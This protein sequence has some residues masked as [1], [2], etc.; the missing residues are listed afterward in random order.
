MV[1]VKS[2]AVN[3][4]H[5]RRTDQVLEVDFPYMQTSV[6]ME[7]KSTEAVAVLVKQMYTFRTQLKVARLGV[8][9]VGWGGN[10]GS[11]LTGALISNKRQISWNTAK[12]PRAP[13]LF[14]SVVMSSTVRVGANSAG[15]DV[16]A[17]MHELLPMVHPDEIVLGG[18]DINRAN[19]AHAMQRAKVFDYDLQ[20]RLI[21]HMESL[22]P[23]PS[24]YYPDFIASNQ[25]QRADNVL[26]GDNK[27][28]HLNIIRQNIREFKRDKNVDQVI[29]LWTATTE[30]FSEVVP[31]I[32]DTAENLLDAINASEEEISPSTLFA[33][34]SIL[35]GAPYINGSP[36]NTFV[37][38]CIQLAERKG[39]FIAGD[40][41]KSG[42]TKFKSVMI[43]FLV[44]AGIKPTAIVSYNH[45]GNNDGHNLSAPSQF[46]SK[47]ISKSNVVDDMVKSNRIL[48]R[49]DEHPDHIVVIKY[50]PT[51]ADSKR[52]MDEY[53]S[54]IFMGGTNTVIT[55]NTCEDSLLAAPLILD[56]VI[57]CELFCRITYKTSSTDGFMPFH[58]VLSFLGYML[59][60][61]LVP[62]GTPVVNALFKQRACIE[63]VL[64]VCSGLPVEDDLR[65]EHHV[66]SV[67]MRNRSESNC[68]IVKNVCR[69]D[70]EEF[71]A[72]GSLANGNGSVTSSRSRTRPG[73]SKPKV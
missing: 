24:V 55:H 41:F 1:F 21:P 18:W 38:G 44:N 3:G 68:N 30:R 40:D 27:T 67:D 56:L 63:N 12:G 39:V 22:A 19:L 59:K 57:L 70:H 14:G 61:P 65:L 45:L 35:E 10:N 29:V 53:T 7:P 9:L 72:N 71:Y 58:H 62:S 42:Q 28:E 49:D 43:D 60:A 36:Q 69:R 6:E 20:R 73:D 37:P 2:F 47:E 23:L 52:A 13:N 54:E 17:P 33:V 32:N 16:F 34:A 50:V 8:M 15:E 64:R 25:E 48:F 46:R 11:T 26:P 31:G 4:S 51:V 66:H 5:V